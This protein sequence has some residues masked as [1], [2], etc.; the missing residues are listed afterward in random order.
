M[1]KPFDARFRDLLVRLDEHRKILF[2]EVF[3]MSLTQSAEQRDKEKHRAETQERT[4][5]SSEQATA[6]PYSSGTPSSTSK[7]TL[8]EKTPASDTTRYPRADLDGKG[9]AE[10]AEYMKT[11]KERILRWLSAP[12]FANIKDSIEEL[13][14]ENTGSW[15]FDQPWYTQWLGCQLEEKEQGQLPL[16]RFGPNVVWLHGRS[17]AASQ[18]SQFFRLLT[19]S[20]TVNRES[21]CRQDIPCMADSGHT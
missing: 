21:G 5:E 16:R 8:P 10:E 11:T 7:E 1:W 20:R 2:D 15:V 6:G 17:W 4:K 13:R 14:Q 12:N 19:W 9:K 18:V 3:L